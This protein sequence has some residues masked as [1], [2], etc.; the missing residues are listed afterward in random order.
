MKKT[1]NKRLFIIADFAA[2]IIVGAIALIII[3]VIVN[4]IT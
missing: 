2:E 3:A 4:F 1:L